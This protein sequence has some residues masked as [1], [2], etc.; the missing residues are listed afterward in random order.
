LFVIGLLADKNCVCAVG[1]SAS[2]G[3]RQF[4]GWKKDEWRKQATGVS[5]VPPEKRPRTKDEDEKD[6][7]R[8][9]NQIQT[10]GFWAKLSCPCGAQALWAVVVFR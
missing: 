2:N 10:P 5:L 3:L 4:A 9:L 6:W 8:T 7:D 1:D